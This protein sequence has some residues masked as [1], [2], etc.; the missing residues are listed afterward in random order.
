VRRFAKHILDDFQR[1]QIGPAR[2]LLVMA[3]PITLSSRSLMRLAV[4][5]L[6][7]QIG[8]STCRTCGVST[9][10]IGSEPITGDT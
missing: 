1:R 5:C 3:Q 8:R 2:S 7:R 4:T 9:I 6:S 10:A